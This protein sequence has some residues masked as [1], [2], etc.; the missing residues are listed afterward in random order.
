ME[1]STPPCN[2]RKSVLIYVTFGDSLKAVQSIAG[3]KE[4]KG[5][6]EEKGWRDAG[7]AA[8]PVPGPHSRSQTVQVAGVI[9]LDRS[10]SL[11]FF[12]SLR[13]GGEFRCGGRQETPSLRSDR[14]AGEKGVGNYIPGV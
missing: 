2:P 4:G 9:L 8:P 3:R 7:I 1:A 11:Y 12:A 14:P 5:E 6:R 10:S 13:L